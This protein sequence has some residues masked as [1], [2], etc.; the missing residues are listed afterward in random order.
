MEK[1]LSSVVDALKD[2]SPEQ[3]RLALAIGATAAA[4]ST[5]TAVV[6]CLL[7]R[8]NG[9]GEQ[10][11]HA[12]APSGETK[13]MNGASSN[14]VVKPNDST[15]IYESESSAR[16][17]M[18]F[19]YTPTRTSYAQRLRTI[20]ESFDFPLRVARKFKE[21]T[22]QTGNENTMAL[23]IGCAT[24]ASV[25]EMSKYFNKVIGLDYSEI[26]IHLAKELVQD[27]GKAH[28]HRVTYTA[29]DQGDIT[30]ERTTYAPHGTFPERC[31]FYC[32]DAM[33][34]FAEKGATHLTP[35]PSGHYDDVMWYKV[36][37]GVQFDAVLA[38]NLLCRVP[39]PRRLLDAFGRLL[40]P[41]GVLVLVSPYS[42]WEGATPRERWIGGRPGGPRSEDAVKEILSPA[43]ELLSETDE[44]FLIRDHVR[45]Y[46]LGFSHCTVWR[47]R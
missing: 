32:G 10:Q 27:T 44:A 37:P 21:F 8:G 4:S 20:S 2:L 13:K 22:P 15:K 34:L 41:G 23:D 39:D 3:K 46:Q 1:K 31:E 35:H 16:Q 40:R 33:N 9:S 28:R 26:F 19:H 12:A 47:R 45:R 25:L 29:P 5:V 11:V 17:Y 43:F 30:V 42:W 6:M 24:G 18:E 36:P 14:G 7:R 38:A